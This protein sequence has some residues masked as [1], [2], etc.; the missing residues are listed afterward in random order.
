MRYFRTVHF[1]EA[2]L[3]TYSLYLHI[4]LLN[5]DGG[6][7]QL[8]VVLDL[9]VSELVGLG[10]VEHGLGVLDFAASAQE[11]QGEVVLVL[12][13]DVLIHQQRRD[14]G[15]HDGS[16]DGAGLDDVHKGLLAQIASA[17]R[18]RDLPQHSW[19]SRHCSTRHMYS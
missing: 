17:S 8:E 7:D 14:A 1:K 3:Y 5:I 12:L 15:P 13:S 2:K 11:F 18:R 10:G 19:K 9:P 16:A 4:D 6:A